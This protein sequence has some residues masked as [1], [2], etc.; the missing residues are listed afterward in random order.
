MSSMSTTRAGGSR[1]SEPPWSA[2]TRGRSRHRSRT[3]HSRACKQGFAVTAFLRSCAARSIGP[4]QQ[5]AG[6]EFRDSRS[7]FMRIKIMANIANVTILPLEP[8][9]VASIPRGVDVTVRAEITPNETN[10]LWTGDYHVIVE[11]DPIELKDLTVLDD[12]V[13]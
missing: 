2:G 8:A 1:A 7:T 10:A 3:R 6:F 13:T 12:D 5:A 11:A 9:H 4:L